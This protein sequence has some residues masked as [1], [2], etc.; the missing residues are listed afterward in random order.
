MLM[1]MVL[2]FIIYFVCQQQLHVT[3]HCSGRGKTYNSQFYC[4]TFNSL[5]KQGGISAPDCH[6]ITLNEGCKYFP[7]IKMWCAYIL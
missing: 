4:G 5:Q 1:I 7:E 3:W 2:W 6:S